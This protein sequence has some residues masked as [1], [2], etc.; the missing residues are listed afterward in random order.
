MNVSLFLK[1]LFLIFLVHLNTYGQ[2]VN[3]SDPANNPT[4]INPQIYMISGACTSQGS[5]TQAALSQ[6]SKIKDVFSSLKDN[7]ACQGVRESVNAS[8]TQIQE[9]LNKVG[10][11][12]NA[13]GT[14][15][16]LSS[17]GKDISTLRNFVREGSYLEGIA[18]TMFMIK[19]MSYQAISSTYASP[20]DPQESQVAGA[21]QSMG[22]RVHS[23]ISLGLS[24]F[25]N[26][27]DALTVA[28]ADC[29]DDA[30]TGL[31]AT[32]LVHTLAAFAGAGQDSQIFGIGHAL[33][34]FINLT[35]RAKYIRAIRKLNDQ[36]F[37]SSMSCL[38]ESTAEGY[39]SALDGRYL[40]EEIVNNHNIK[41][42]TVKRTVKNQA[43]GQV[44]QVDDQIIVGVSENFQKMHLKG[45]LAGYF[46]LS[47]QLQIVND[48]IQKL[49]YGITPQLPTEATFQITTMKAI[50]DFMA[51]VKSIQG[52]FN[53]QKNFLLD[54]NSG[55]SLGAKQGL[56]KAMIISAFGQMSGGDP[57]GPPGFRSSGATGN[58]FQQAAGGGAIQ[59]FFAIMGMKEIPA[60][61]LGRGTVG[62]TLYNGDPIAWLNG[63]YQDEPK[64]RTPEDYAKE[65]AQ[66]M[67]KIFNDARKI[68]DAFYTKYFIVD[69]VQLINDSLLGLDSNVRDAF[70]HI[71]V[72]L[73]DLAERIQNRGKDTSFQPS[74]RQTRYKLGQVLGRFKAIR[75]LGLEMI[76]S[77]I[78]SQTL[79]SKIRKLSDVLIK[80][81]YDQ[82]EIQTARAGLL[83]NRMV[84]FVL[85]DYTMTIRDR[86]QLN[87]YVNDMLLAEGYNSLQQMFNM[88][89]VSY[90]RAK[91]DL[92]NALE[93]HRKNIHSLEEVVEDVFARHIIEKG[94][95]AQ[96]LELT[97]DELK[98]QAA[99]DA[100]YSAWEPLP[101]DSN[102]YVSYIRRSLRALTNDFW[103]TVTTRG[104]DRYG[105][106]NF[107]ERLMG[108][109]EAIK[110]QTI[111]R[112]TISNEFNSAETEKALLCTQTLA[113][114]NLYPYWYFCKDAVLK[115]SFMKENINDPQLK[116][117]AL[118]YLSVPFA[119]KFAEGI[120]NGDRKHATPLQKSLNFSKRICSLRDFHRRNEVARV[121]A[122]MITNG[123]DY[124][125]QFMKI[126][127]ENIPPTPP[128]PSP[129]AEAPAPRL[130]VGSA[131]SR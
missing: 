38:L 110:G 73:G 23:G 42:S 44:E 33:N 8:L 1:S 49:Q 61:V 97:Y 63:R 108:Y 18:K 32:S 85:Y 57:D 41:K 43:T 128:L 114:N 99:Y 24:Q 126:I 82:F 83:A 31:V 2:G 90:S 124:E 28:K 27:V 117:M 119:K 13:T 11:A 92:D 10:N 115:S 91:T 113:F 15:S 101:G 81:I 120:P 6:T 102:S 72:Y 60:A 9:T 39:C 20:T 54:K 106:P 45:P 26:T 12:N 67:D 48:W 86:N 121:S 65:I 98:M 47:R 125:T 55:L 84:G 116:A 4:S 52:P 88:S 103:M 89:S 129:P 112:T 46:I 78:P 56:L 79:D 87:P 30:Q 105:Y 16:S 77:N 14:P 75:D 100:V 80:E 64:F 111:V 68:A 51:T 131:K 122:A 29:L 69:K 40:L 3:S 34:N 109:W 96:G 5:W 22:Q 25:N 94:R 53:Q 58:F 123:A 71:D 37:I 66:N 36:Q 19:S 35:Q 74:I 59:L 17:L 104:G 95:Q 70:V 107:G 93:I 7:P 127:D 62:E 118:D 76:K 21:V 130:G 50:Q